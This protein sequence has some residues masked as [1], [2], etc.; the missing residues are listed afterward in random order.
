MT[1]TTP[2]ETGST[3]APATP[4]AAQTFLQWLTGEL[5]AG[6]KFLENFFASFVNSEVAALAPFAE[7]A[8]SAL[9]TDISAIFNGGLSA[10]ANAVAPVLTQTAEQAAAAGIQAGG[11]S[12]IAAVSGALANAQANQQSAN[13]NP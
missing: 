11:S 2:T 4:A 9:I 7:Q 6:W 10:Y 13:Q 1:G 8:V 5:D 12:L 3:S